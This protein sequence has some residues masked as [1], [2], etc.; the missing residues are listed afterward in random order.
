MSHSPTAFLKQ[1]DESRLLQALDDESFMRDYREVCKSYD[2]YHADTDMRIGA[3][4]WRQDD[5]VAYFCAE[6]GLHESLPIYSGGLASSRATS[7]KRRATC[8]CP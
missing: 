2:D 3:G 8:G 6:F 4:G 1:I 5:R 7:A